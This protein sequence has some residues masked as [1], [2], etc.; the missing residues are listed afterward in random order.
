[1]RVVSY[2][3]ESY[4]PFRE[5]ARMELRP[6]TI[7]F[8][9]NSSG[10]SAVLRSLR[11]IFSSITT[12]STEPV[13]LN[14]DRINFGSRFTDLVHGKSFHGHITLGLSLELDSGQKI[15]FTTKIQNIQGTNF[16]QP[17]SFVSEFIVKEPVQKKMNLAIVADPPDRKQLAS[18]YLDEEDDTAK[19]QYI[20]FNGI[21]PKTTQ[22]LLLDG[23]TFLEDLRSSVREL[24]AT[25]QHIGPFRSQIRKVYESRMEHPI[26]L[27]GSGAPYILEADPDLL[28]ATGKWYLQF[29]DGWELSL[30]PLGE[31]FCL[32]LK[33]GDTT[34]NLAE[35]GQGMQQILPIIV[36]QLSRQMKTDH[37]F[38]D[39]IEQPELHL[40]TAAQAPLG[41]LFLD[42]A[43]ANK[44][45]LIVETHSENLLLRIR[46]RIAEGIDPNLV[47]LYWIE[48][49]V[50]G[51]STL[52]KIDINENGELSWWKKGVFSE[53]Y[54]E[55]KAIA[56]ARNHEG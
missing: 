9:R 20:P 30:K 35:A 27:D 37:S 7:I 6:L 31:A 54:Q 52:I 4:K 44:G 15:D 32:L 34:I 10:K 40:H 13:P 12:Q 26:D 33:R 29:M 51:F 45:Q 5:M 46:R 36:Q 56:K 23:W 41:D 48:D 21:L 11:Q 50:D 49:H 3:L 42:T 39:L 28:E 38:I 55:V 16:S 24:E 17:R 43:L 22:T 19:I 2:S 18:I 1:M 8:G 14:V 47:A 53:N 25:L